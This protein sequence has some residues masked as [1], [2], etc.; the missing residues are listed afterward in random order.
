M[1]SISD[2]NWLIKICCCNSGGHKRWTKWWQ[3]S[4]ATKA[5]QVGGT[6]TISWSRA[7][8]QTWEKPFVHAS[9]ATKFVDV[10]FNITLPKAGAQNQIKRCNTK[11]NTSLYREESSGHGATMA[12]TGPITI[13]TSWIQLFRAHDT[14]VPFSNHQQTMWHSAKYVSNW[15]ISATNTLKLT[16]SINIWY[17]VFLSAVLSWFMVQLWPKRRAAPCCGGTSCHKK[18]DRQIVG[19]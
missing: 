6:W 2:V 5:W 14:I 10:V 17:Q 3:E 8:C 15:I 13:E 7:V 12:D 19:L 4:C 1:I 11:K 9:V 18:G 16:T